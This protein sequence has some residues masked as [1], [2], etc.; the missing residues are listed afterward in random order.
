MDAKHSECR[1]H[2]K[3]IQYKLPIVKPLSQQQK[4]AIINIF[5]ANWD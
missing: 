5:M 1:A 3:C 4:A 2:C